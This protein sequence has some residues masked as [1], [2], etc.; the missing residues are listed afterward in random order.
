MLTDLL[1]LR[2]EEDLADV[3]VDVLDGHLLIEVPNGILRAGTE[4]IAAGVHNHLVRIGLI[5]ISVD[6]AE[7]LV[8]SDV[9]LQF[10][11]L[12]HG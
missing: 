1:I 4:V 6:G 2:A 12:R 7:C 9:A 10:N 5:D 8:E 3:L 11:F